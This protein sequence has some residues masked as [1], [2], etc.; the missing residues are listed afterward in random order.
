MVKLP[1]SMLK[2]SPTLIL[3][4][5]MFWKNMMFPAEEASVMPNAT[6]VGQLLPEHVN[7]TLPLLTAAPAEGAEKV[8]N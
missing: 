4:A 1:D 2:L 6:T 5:A 8:V 3:R 7:V